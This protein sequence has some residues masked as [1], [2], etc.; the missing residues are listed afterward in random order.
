ME[1]IILTVI[2]DLPCRQA[3]LIRNLYPTK[4]PNRWDS[5]LRRNDA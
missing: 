3:G 1:V 4:F 5:C 2:P